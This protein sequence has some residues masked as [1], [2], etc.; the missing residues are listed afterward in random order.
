[1]SNQTEKVFADGFIFKRK[2]NAPEFVVGSQSIKVDEAIAFL[3]LYQKDG[4]VN[5]DIK[6]SKGGKYYCEL[7]TWEPKASGG[8]NSSRPKADIMDVLK[9][10][11]T[12]SDE[13]LF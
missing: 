11:V 10:A 12:S 13:V 4:W 1:M 6:Q 5:L 7:D 8:E 2:E 9:T 3:Q